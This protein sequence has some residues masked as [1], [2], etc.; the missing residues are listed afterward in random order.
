MDF[1]RSDDWWLAL[2]EL[3]GDDLIDAGPMEFPACEKPDDVTPIEAQETLVAFSKFVQ[4]MRRKRGISLE[5]LA[6]D[7]DLDPGEL[8]LI[9]RGLGQ[10]PEPRVVHQLAKAF[11][12][13][14]GR[15]MQLAGLTVARDPS[16]QQQAV[17]FAARS[18]PVQKLSKEENQALEEFV[19]IL[20]EKDT[21]RR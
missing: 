17:R 18:E 1:K 11:S 12:V 20:S 6:M 5:R 19:A 4:F 8:L 9:E 15:L 13:P 14:P 3:E 2:V 21:R 16:F 7:I 10:T